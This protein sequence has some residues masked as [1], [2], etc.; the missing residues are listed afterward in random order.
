MV[1]SYF[2]LLR[3][4]F[5]QSHRAGSTNHSLCIV[6]TVETR[7]T[8]RERLIFARNIAKFWNIVKFWDPVSLRASYSGAGP[9][10]VYNVGL[11]H[12]LVVYAPQATIRMLSNAL[13]MFLKH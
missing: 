8:S 13:V 11:N 7:K 1:R 6:S 2:L 5:A 4:N 12:I 10:L 9:G 3:D